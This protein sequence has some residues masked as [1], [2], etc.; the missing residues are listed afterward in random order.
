M[1]SFL[2][3][4]DFLKSFRLFFSYLQAFLEF[5]ELIERNWLGRTEMYRNSPL[6]AR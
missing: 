5:I 2:G 6:V 3:V 4:E 1:E